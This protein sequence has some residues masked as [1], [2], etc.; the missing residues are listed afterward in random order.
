MKKLMWC[1][2]FLMPWTLSAQV[3]ISGKVSSQSE[4]SG[5]PGATIRFDENRSI[6]STN[7]AGNYQVKLKEGEH[8][9]TISFIG[10]Q[11]T[12][13]TINLTK[14]EVI[15][16]QLRGRAFLQDEV[17]VEATRAKE[18]SAT[19][20]TNV[21]KEDI[22]ALNLGQDLPILL[23]QTPSVVTTSDAG[24]G[25]GY[26]GLRIRGSDGTRINVTVNGIP[27]N[28]A[29][30]HG[31]F[32][33]NMPDLASS[34]E[35]IQIQRGV[36]TSTNGA[37]A[38]G[39]SINMQTTILKEKAYGEIANSFGSFNTRKHTVQF[40]SGLIDNKFA[41]DGRLSQIKSDGFI[42]RASSDLQSYYLSG[43]YYG[44]KT[45]LKAIM[46]GG[47]EK[48]YQSWYGTPES[49]VN[50]DREGMLA[51][52]AN[53]G[54]SQSQI[55]NLLNSGRSYNFYQYDNQVD[56]Y[57]QDHYQLLI[58][59]EFNKK[60]SANLNFHYT[61]G[62]GY[63][64]EFRADNDF[65]DYGLNSPIIGNDT[66]NSTDL[67]RRRWL[68]NHFGGLTYSL[69]YAASNK[70]NLT[71]GGGYNLYEGDHFGE[72]IWSEIAANTSIRERYYD[73]VGKKR[74]F[75]SYLKADY[76]I[77]ENLTAFADLQVR[78]ID[79]STNGNDNDLRIIDVE[80]DFLFFNPKAGINY[81]FNSITSAYVSYSVSNREPV[82]N[83]FI[84]APVGEK[85]EHEQ[86]NNLEFG[87]QVNDKDY[88]FHANIF[89]MDYKNQ[90]VL[91]GELNDVGST[92]R[93]N[94]E[95]SYRAGI[96]LSAGITISKK[97]SLSGNMTM[98]RNKIAEFDDYFYDYVSG[99]T[100]IT[101]IE[102]ADISF[103]PDFIAAST[104]E[105]RP[106]K[107]MTV[108]LLTK[109]VGQQFLDNTQS[110]DKKIDSYLVNDIRLNYVVKDVLFKEM[111]FTLLIN[112]A[113]DELYSP[114]GYTYS[115]GVGEVITENFFYPQAG[116]NFLAG[117]TLKF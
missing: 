31:V 60:L 81:R 56:N 28:D 32:W 92:V 64:E 69:N 82:R 76:A 94:V 22:E 48:T 34:T 11:D 117:V 17:M 20:F 103:S 57:S 89:H 109:H 74:D 77:T 80:E 21:S 68:D 114:N 85:P 47:N 63:Y 59:H 98:S 29:E 87:V 96:E 105:Y 19:T 99:E 101:R 27:I 115:Y 15:N 116:T 41:F 66:I 102:D 18:N 93:Q 54:Y 49:R 53:E 107:N 104:I 25:V 113:F 40:G 24:A 42:D 108:S 58:A 65:A 112:N 83:D 5:L 86:L 70:L 33:V 1:M 36:G 35:S 23:Q 51:H 100:I 10:Y 50:N 110:N 44:E 79:Y 97:L 84:D 39:A 8:R 72:I 6:I 12:T 30:S 88:F 9:M 37:A 78:T 95:N 61:R 52:A 46:F 75:N 38:F 45:I 3:T 4:N 16:V 90:L 71:L 26:T 43:A 67:I 13:L 2:M 73:N 111:N 106:I 55:D 14:S 91:T 7:N 62:E